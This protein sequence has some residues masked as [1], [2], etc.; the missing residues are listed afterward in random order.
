MCKGCN[1]TVLWHPK[2]WTIWQLAFCACQGLCCI[3]LGVVLWI[4]MGGAVEGEDRSVVVLWVVRC[5]W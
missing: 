4:L 1:L 2:D 5:C 3:I